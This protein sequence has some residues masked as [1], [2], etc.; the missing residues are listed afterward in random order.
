MM[1]QRVEERLPLQTRVKIWLLLA[2]LSLTL[3]VL[4]LLELFKSDEV[5]MET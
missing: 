4:V 5:V 3:S 2:K 1:N